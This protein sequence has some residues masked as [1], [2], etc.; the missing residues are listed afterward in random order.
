M[1][2]L[3]HHHSASRAPWG[4]TCPEALTPLLSALVNGLGE[5]QEHRAVIALA[6]LA[7]SEGLLSDEVEFRRAE[8]RLDAAFVAFKEDRK[9]SA[10][11]PLSTNAASG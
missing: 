4:R 5:L 8:A 3:P 9:R 6:R 7:E 1:R 10:A 2:F 11:S